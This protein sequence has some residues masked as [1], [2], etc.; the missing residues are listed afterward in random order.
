MDISSDVIM[1]KTPRKSTSS[2]SR[3]C[4]DRLYNSRKKTPA[5][6]VEEISKSPRVS[7]EA[8][9]KKDSVG[10]FRGL[11]KHALAS[12]Q[13][14]EK[15]RQHYIDEELAECTFKPNLKHNKKH[16][17]GI[18]N[19][20]NVKECNK[21]EVP[22]VLHGLLEKETVVPEPS[23]MIN[24]MEQQEE[25]ESK[26]QGSFLS[27]LTSLQLFS[28][29][30]Q[31]LKDKE[32]C[33]AID[34]VAT[35]MSIHEEEDYKVDNIVLSSNTS[36]SKFCSI[37]REGEDSDGISGGALVQLASCQHYAHIS[38]LQQQLQARWSG[39]KISFAYL[40]C[41]EC[42][43]PLCHDTL[44]QH[45]TPHLQLKQA[46]EALCLQQA[47]VDELL[48]DFDTQLETDPEDTTAQCMAALS[49]Y[50]CSQCSEPFCG[51]RVDCAQDNELDLRAMKC[52]SCA[53]NRSDVAVLKQETK[54]ASADT[55]VS[56]W[57]GKCRVHGYKFAIYKCDSCCAVA[58]WDCRSNHYCERCHSQASSTKDFKCPGEEKCPLGIAHP[59]N[60][61]GVHGTVD[62][63]FVIGCSKCFLGGNA[64]GM[65]FELATDSSSRGA[66]DNWRDRF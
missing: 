57:R 27:A 17:G 65:E 19:K 59:P 64:E 14:S 33:D 52:L 60:K 63:G 44:Y 45:L 10:V 30:L 51:G 24:D 58:I 8:A 62:D 39:K 50:L 66:V 9:N 5:K 25:E 47:Q 13:K 35:Q 4:F 23:I 48:V 54:K 53:F 29:V 61:A 16:V 21:S 2:A 43:T 15:R 34:L 46:V 40:T 26:R 18:K 55:S 28:I 38:C 36:S 31:Q 41:G 56:E 20:I 3:N 11:Y 6:K 49:C 12:A 32:S 1:C 22:I 7:S 37:C 42:R